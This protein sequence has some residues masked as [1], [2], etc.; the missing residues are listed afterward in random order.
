MLFSTILF[1][2][3]S[4]L[5]ILSSIFVVFSKST[6]TSAMFL[7]FAFVNASALFLMIGAEFLA[8]LLIIV[9]VGAIAILFLFVVMMLDVEA[10]KEYN[11]KKYVPVLSLVS[12]VFVTQIY[13]ILSNSLKPDEITGKAYFFLKH[14]RMPDDISNAKAIGNILYTEFFL[15]FQLSGLILFVAMIG[16]IILTLKE[17]DNFKKVQNISKQVFRRKE[18]SIEIIKVKSNKGLD[19]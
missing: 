12:V 3:F 16:A 17:S 14:H 15:Q 4:I 9:Y 13:I 8:M 6:I 10:K 2:Q 18:D 19:V 11:L 1:Y 7:I 5:L